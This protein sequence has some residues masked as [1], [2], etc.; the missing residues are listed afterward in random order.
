MTVIHGD[1]DRAHAQAAAELF[2]KTS[3]VLLRPSAPFRLVS[4]RFSPVY[5]DCRRLISF[6]EARRDM[7]ALAEEHLR[8]QPEVGA[9]DLVAGGETAGIPYAAWLADRLALP[10]I[11]VRKEPKAYGRGKR[12]E[13]VLNPGARV[14]LVEDLA[15]DGKSKHIFVEAL[16]EAGGV[17]SHCFVLFHYAI[18]PASIQR[19]E[20]EFGLTLSALCR[21]KDV[22]E[23][24]RRSGALAREELNSLDAFLEAPDQWSD[25]Y[26]NTLSKAG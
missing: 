7:L 16:R 17:C 22:V 13:G 20:Q 1:H 2:L 23:A 18:F 19:L 10:M 4:G 21:L 14:L 26:S 11:Y 12:I 24:A 9:F 8:T 6:P 15:T 5:V 3:S 25:A